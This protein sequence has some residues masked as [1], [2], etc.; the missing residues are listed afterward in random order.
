MSAAAANATVTHRPVEWSGVAYRMVAVPAVASRA[1]SV[2]QVVVALSAMSSPRARLGLTE[3]PHGHAR[4][5]EAA[6]AAAAFIPG[7]PWVADG[8]P[9]W[10]AFAHPGDALAATA[11]GL[12]AQVL[13][14][15]MAEI[16]GLW[17][18]QPAD[19]R[20][21]FL[22]AREARDRPALLAGP[23]AAPLSRRM[24]GRIAAAGRLDGVLAA[25]GRIVVFR[26]AA[27]RVHPLGAAYD[28]VVARGGEATARRIIIGKESE[29]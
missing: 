13:A 29:T 16:R 8:V 11:A 28:L 18:V 19:V 9:A 4:I 21:R 26:A 17:R 23:E 7:L 22:D 20:G 2:S 5:V 12:H 6:M 10:I 1:R 14:A 27:I 15:G 25:D 3:T 24:G